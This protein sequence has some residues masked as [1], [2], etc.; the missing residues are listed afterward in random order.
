MLAWEKKGKF[1]ELVVYTV[2]RLRY[3]SQRTAV[4]GRRTGEGGR[5]EC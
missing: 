5:V 1:F 3:G 2:R 4:L